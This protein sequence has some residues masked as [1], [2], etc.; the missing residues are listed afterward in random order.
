MCVCEYMGPLMDGKAKE[1]KLEKSMLQKLTV[2][3]VIKKSTKLIAKKPYSFTSELCD[4]TI[5]GGGS[6]ANR[7]IQVRLQTIRKHEKCQK[8]MEKMSI[9]IFI[10]VS[11]T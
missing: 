8:S 6:G 11:C 5:C 7:T 1:N 3:C 9:V 10:H 4:Q 2:H